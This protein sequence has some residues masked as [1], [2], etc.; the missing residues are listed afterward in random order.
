[1]VEPG[2]SVIIC[3]FNSSRRIVATLTCLKQQIVRNDINWEIVLVDNACTDDT[4][5]IAKTL[6]NGQQISFTIVSQPIPGLSYAREKGIACAK[7]NFLLFC[8]DDNW[9]SDHYIEQVFELMNSNSEIAAL[10][11]LGS[12]VFETVPPKAIKE[13]P[14]PYAVGPQLGAE[15]YLPARV[16]LYGAATTYRREAL[17]T[18]QN[19]GFKFYLTGRLGGKLM[20]GEDRELGAVLSLAGFRQYYSDRLTFAHFIPKERLTKHYYNGL[21]LGACY[22]FP[23]LLAYSVLLEEKFSNRKK[24]KSSFFWSFLSYQFLRIKNLLAIRDVK[25]LSLELR[26]W[27]LSSCELVKNRSI[28]KNIISETRARNYYA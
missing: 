13:A 26:T 18:I 24:I 28:Y 7:Y 23:V 16:T 11:G 6:L 2:V 19:K 20:T 17:A 14:G 4:V 22:S 10:G 1:M 25:K 21:L 5:A 8:D 9:L 12:P 3:C 15:G 27:F